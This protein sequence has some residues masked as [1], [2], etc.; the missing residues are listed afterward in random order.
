M[1]E[2]TSDIVIYQTN[3]GQTSSDVRSENE[4]VWLSKVQMADLCMQTR[5]SIGM[6]INNV[7]NESEL[8]KSSTIKDS[9][10][11]QKEGS[12]TVQRKIEYNSCREAM[13]R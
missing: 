5:Q 7:F 2:N 8:D 10:I 11:V 1:R 3:D 4:T 6:H 13:N 9:F 12:R